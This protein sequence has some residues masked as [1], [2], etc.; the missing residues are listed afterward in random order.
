MYDHPY[1]PSTSMD[2][3]IGIPVQSA[4]DATRFSPDCDWSSKRRGAVPRI[5]ASSFVST[6]S[7]E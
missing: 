4:L 2:S 1:T 5:T 6:K 7:H 3:A